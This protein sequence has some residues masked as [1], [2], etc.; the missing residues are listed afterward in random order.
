V[1]GW[2]SRRA[3]TRRTQISAENSLRSVLSVYWITKFVIGFL[4]QVIVPALRS[5]L[6]MH[7]ICCSNTIHA[8]AEFLNQDG[9]SRKNPIRNARFG[10]AGAQAYGSKVGASRQFLSWMLASIGPGE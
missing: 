7:V 3:P 6:S 2:F 8:S 10:F 4:F 9:K 5:R 1:S